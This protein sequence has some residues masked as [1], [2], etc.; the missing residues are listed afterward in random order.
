MTP[1]APSQH[2]DDEEEEDDL[3]NYDAT[4]EAIQLRASLHSAAKR[5]LKIFAKGVAALGCVPV[6]IGDSDAEKPGPDEQIASIM[7][8]P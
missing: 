4:A 6:L 3:V 2:V 1:H 8:S 7:L 5:R